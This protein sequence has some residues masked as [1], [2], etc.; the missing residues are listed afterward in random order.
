M[1]VAPAPDGL[2]QWLESPDGSRLLAAFDR[3]PLRRG[4][5]VSGPGQADNLIFI[6]RSGRVRVYL[7]SEQR[8]LTLAFLHPGD[9]YTTHTPAWVMAV[10]SGELLVMGTRAFSRF[11]MEVPSAMGSVMRVLGRLLHHTVDLVE[12]LV[13]R[14]ANQRLSHFLI[15]VARRHQGADT[16]VWVVPLQFTV[17]EIALL[18]G[19][20]RQT[21]STALNELQREGIVSRQ[22]RRE[23]LINDM[24]RL[25]A[26]CSR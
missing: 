2:L 5:L 13:F 8:E 17:T 12:T 3:R 4:Q 22:G 21:I 23:L 24:P 9:V 18:L 14:D 16:A 26:W 10:E 19:T 20:T 25:Q 6:V 7:S 15:A 1:S 11:L